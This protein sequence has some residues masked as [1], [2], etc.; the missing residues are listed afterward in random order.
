MRLLLAAVSQI[1][2]ALGN[3]DHAATEK[4]ARSVGMQLVNDLAGA[5][6]SILLK[7]PK[8]FKALGLSTHVAFDDLAKSVAA[9]KPHEQLLSELGTLTNKCVGCHAGYSLK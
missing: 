2:T 5:E 6:K 3:N 9:R 7:L 8:S 1:H 4:A